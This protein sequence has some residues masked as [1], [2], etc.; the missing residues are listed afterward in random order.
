MNTY[1]FQLFSKKKKKK[2]SFVAPKNNSQNLKSKYSQKSY[3]IFNPIYKWFLYASENRLQN[4]SV[5]WIELIFY[6]YSPTHR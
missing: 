6:F 1:F 5:K 2:Q 3:M 4:R